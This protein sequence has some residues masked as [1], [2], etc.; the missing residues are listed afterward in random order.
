MKKEGTM[1][2][3]ITTILTNTTVRGNADIEALLIKQATIAAP[4]AD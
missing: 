4:W 3:V 1:K 2:D